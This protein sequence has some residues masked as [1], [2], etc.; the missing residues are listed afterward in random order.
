[1]TEPGCPVFE[2]KLTGM[3]TFLKNLKGMRCPESVQPYVVRVEFPANPGDS[4][5]ARIV[6]RPKTR[7][8]LPNKGLRKGN[9][10][11]TA[12]PGASTTSC[13]LNEVPFAC[14]SRTQYNVMKGELSN[15]GDAPVVFSPLIRMKPSQYQSCNNA[16]RPSRVM[17][18]SPCVGVNQP[19]EAGVVGWCAAV[20]RVVGRFTTRAVS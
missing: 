7:N 15:G 18:V 11:K 8:L 10:C 5:S 12:A 17:F 4:V 6:W 2:E 19:D 9:V 14:L 13:A 1:M 20:T 3:F 16:L